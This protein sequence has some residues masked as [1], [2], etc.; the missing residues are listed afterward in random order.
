MISKRKFPD[1]PADPLDVPEA[2]PLS[3]LLPLD[4]APKLRNLFGFIIN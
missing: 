3:E 2:L 1:P 4:A